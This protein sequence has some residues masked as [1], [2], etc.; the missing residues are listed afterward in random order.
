MSVS[1]TVR[2]V[3]TAGV[4]TV[5]KIM[6]VVFRAKSNYISGDDERSRNGISQ[7]GL[8]IWL[9]YITKEEK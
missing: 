8:M 3:L 4:K 9:L 7:I 1:V 6:T 2:N 5:M